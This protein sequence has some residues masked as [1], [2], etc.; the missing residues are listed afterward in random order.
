MTSYVYIF[1]YNSNSID[2]IEI[3]HVREEL[4]NDDIE[5]ILDFDFDYN[6]GS[7]EYMVSKRKL[8]ITNRGKGYA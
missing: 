5:A 7:I 6:I 2:E 3:Q 4:Q 1:D 8:N